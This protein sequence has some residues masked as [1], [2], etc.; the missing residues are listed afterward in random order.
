MLYHILPLVVTCV[1]IWATTLL[2]LYDASENPL[3]V[4]SRKGLTRFTLNM[5][6][7]QGS[8]ECDTWHLFLICAILRVSSHGCVSCTSFALPLK[9]VSVLAS[10]PNSL[11]HVPNIVLEAESI[12]RKL[13]AKLSLPLLRWCLNKRRKTP[14]IL[15][16]TSAGS[17]SGFGP[18]TASRTSTTACWIWLEPNHFSSVHA[19][20]SIALALRSTLTDQSRLTISSSVEFSSSPRSCRIPGP[21]EASPVSVRFFVLHKAR[22]P[23]SWMSMCEHE[24]E[25][26]WAL[27]TIQGLGMSCAR[28]HGAPSNDNAR[29]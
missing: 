22:L 6:F 11:T 3:T 24:H 2:V 8:N 17:L 7:M 29:K 12:S 23:H 14:T 25:H 27:L 9:L 1:I 13:V 16:T 4:F 15:G 21:N 19:R 20:F 28:N 10:L 26:V 5:M 18:A